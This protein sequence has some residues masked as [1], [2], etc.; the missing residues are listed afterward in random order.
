[1]AKYKV[2]DAGVLDEIVKYYN[3]CKDITLEDWD[4][5]VIL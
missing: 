3:L 4:G 5:W 2:K 1:M